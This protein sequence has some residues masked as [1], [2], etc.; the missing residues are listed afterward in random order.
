MLALLAF[1]AGIGLC[2]SSTILFPG[3]M[4]IATR[5]LEV[6]FSKLLLIGMNGVGGFFRIAPKKVVQ[7]GLTTTI[8]VSLTAGSFYVAAQHVD[9][10]MSLTRFQVEFIAEN[11]PYIVEAAKKTN[12]DP[13]V[14]VATHGVE[15]GMKPVNPS[16]GQGIGGFYTLVEVLKERYFKPGPIEGIELQEQYE[17]IGTEIHRHCPG[18][19]AIEYNAFFEDRG[20]DAMWDRAD[21]WARYNGVPGYERGVMETAGAI[22]N[23]L[24]GYPDLRG[25]EI[26]LGDGCPSRGPMQNDGYETYYQKVSNLVFAAMVTAEDTD[27]L[28]DEE[29]VVLQEA[30]SWLDI[31]TKLYDQWS[32]N[33]YLE[34]TS[35]PSDFKPTLGRSPYQAISSYSALP[36]PPKG[37]WGPTFG[38]FGGNW[39]VTQWDHG[40]SYGAACID[41]ASL[42]SDSAPIYA[43]VSGVVNLYADGYGNSVMLIENPE[44]L[45]ILLHHRRVHVQNGSWVQAGQHVADQGS[46]G[47]LTGPHAHICYYSKVEGSYV[48]AW[49]YI[50]NL[51]GD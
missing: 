17:L 32:N 21:C 23:N 15:N 36:Q 46:V 44:W 13:G 41:G 34:P 19:R 38:P 6:L 2:I 35:P 43:P 49:R 26:C 42:D 30:P 51:P 7:L 5:Q 22:F 20:S 9:Q 18:N 33:R 16:N 37:E 25:L 3:L 48:Q 27:E 29:G 47:N 10:K 11:W 4:S 50:P 40:A 45:V 28:Y 8:V 31:M 39:M 1:V 12:T 24:P 14:L